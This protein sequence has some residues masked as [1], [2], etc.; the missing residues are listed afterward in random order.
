MKIQLSV[1]GTVLTFK[2]QEQTTPQVC[3]VYKLSHFNL[4]D[5]EN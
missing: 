2:V 3:N 1:P 4:G 5:V